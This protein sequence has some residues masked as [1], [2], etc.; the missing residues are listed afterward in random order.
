M[1]VERLRVISCTI[2]GKPVRLEECKINDFGKPV[3]EDCL[4]RQIKEDL[5]KRNTP[6]AS[7]KA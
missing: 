2:C 5:E 7:Q 1:V 3:H 4:A 6:T